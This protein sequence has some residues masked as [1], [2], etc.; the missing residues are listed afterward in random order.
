MESDTVSTLGTY[1]VES[2]VV[3]AANRRWSPEHA[4]LVSLLLGLLEAGASAGGCAFP[5]LGDSS[6]ELGDSTELQW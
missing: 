5:A 2:A 4:L 1:G 6:V 3:H